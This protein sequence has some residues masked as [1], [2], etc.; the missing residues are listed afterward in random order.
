MERHRRG[1]ITRY[2]Q[3]TARVGRFLLFASQCIQVHSSP[4]TG[5]LQSSRAAG[6]TKR[7]SLT[8]MAVLIKDTIYYRRW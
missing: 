4:L 1:Y 3:R 8:F 7:N 5:A 2:P 6:Q